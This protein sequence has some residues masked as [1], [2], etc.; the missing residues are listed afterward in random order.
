VLHW[1]SKQP[2][3]TK[4]LVAEHRQLARPPLREAVIDLRLAEE[5][6]LSVVDEIGRLRFPDFEPPIQMWRTQIS[7]PVGPP[8]PSPPLLPPNANEAFGWRYHRS[9]GSR[10]IQLRRDGVTFGVVQGYTTWA[11]ARSFARSVVERY[12]GWARN[13][14]VARIAVRYINVLAVPVGEDFDLYLTAGPRVPLG[15]PN[16]LSAF[17][18]RVVIPFSQDEASAI[19]TQALEQVKEATVSVV[20]DIDV[21]SES[22]LQFDA[23]EI[24]ARLDVLRDIKNR[25]FF[26]SVTERALEPFT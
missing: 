16:V 7:F 13:A 6:P 14:S 21:W 2:R 20:L 3:L 15:I 19:V 25:I 22:R 12:C 8:T 26:G 4:S 24:W 18:H 11:D 23:P 10:A 17:L 1:S 5:L 9:D